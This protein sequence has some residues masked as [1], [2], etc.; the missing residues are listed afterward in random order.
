MGLLDNIA[1]YPVIDVHIIKPREEELGFSAMIDNYNQRKSFKKGARDP[2]RR[3]IINRHIQG[4]VY[5]ITLNGDKCILHD[6][7]DKD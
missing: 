4:S 5:G 6:L 3:A 7:I 1:D 2:H